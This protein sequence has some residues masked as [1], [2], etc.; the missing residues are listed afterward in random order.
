MEEITIKLPDYIAYELLLDIIDFSI[1][2]HLENK[3]RKDSKWLKTEVINSY[4]TNK[5]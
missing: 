4:N 5:Q 1:A 2:N 3:T